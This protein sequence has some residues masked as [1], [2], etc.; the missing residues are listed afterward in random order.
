MLCHECSG[1]GLETPAVALCR[2]CLIALCKAHLVALYQ[3]PAT[4]PQL[5]CSH[6]PARAFTAQ[7]AATVPGRV[8]KDLLEVATG[9]H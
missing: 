8:A 5:H 2:F 6:T 3:H 9:T 4:V 1:K 7:P